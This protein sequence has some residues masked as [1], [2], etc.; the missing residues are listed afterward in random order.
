MVPTYSCKNA[1]WPHGSRHRAG[2]SVQVRAPDISKNNTNFDIHWG[3]VSLSSMIGL[4][5]KTSWGGTLGSISASLRSVYLPHGSSWFWWH[6]QEI[7]NINMANT[8]KVEERRWIGAEGQDHTNCKW[9]E[10]LHYTNFLI[11]SISRLQMHILWLLQLS[12]HHLSMLVFFYVSWRF[13]PTP[14]ILGWA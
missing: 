6:Y 10:P 8:S 5:F 13:S 11:H 1:T 12:Q 9:G 2:E 7:G 4:T 14:C 3:I